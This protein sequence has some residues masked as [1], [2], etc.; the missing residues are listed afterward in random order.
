MLLLHS[1][2][3]LPQQRIGNFS[4]RHVIPCIHTCSDIRY[5]VYVYIYIITRECGRRVDCPLAGPIPA[6][7]G[8]AGE[9]LYAKVIDGA[10]GFASRCLMDLVVMEVGQGHTHTHTLAFF[11][12]RTNTWCTRVYVCMRLCIYFAQVMYVCPVLTARD[13]MYQHQHQVS[14][15]RS[16]MFC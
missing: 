16:Y 4:E 10:Y 8:A 3:F 7:P 2:S 6:D 9:G 13:R 11:A 14:N 1:S 5:A 15:N 12:E